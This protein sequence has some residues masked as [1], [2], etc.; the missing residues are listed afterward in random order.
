[1][2]TLAGESLV[3]IATAL[4]RDRTCVGDRVAAAGG[5]AQRLARAPSTISREIR[6]HGG[7]A[8][9]PRGVG[10]PGLLGCGV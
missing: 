7:R 5:I 2:A 6:R 10:W 3:D 9:S 8:A 4:D 1:V